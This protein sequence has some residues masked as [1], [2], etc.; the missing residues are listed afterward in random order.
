MRFT[1][2]G[3]PRFHVDHTPAM[4]DENFAWL[5]ALHVP[6]CSHSK[7]MSMAHQ[8][9]HSIADASFTKV[10]AQ[11]CCAHARQA[12]LNWNKSKHRTGSQA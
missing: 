3:E 6:P 12:S 1:H 9:I 5:Q 10:R 8:H 4:Q 2:S 11:Q 7:F